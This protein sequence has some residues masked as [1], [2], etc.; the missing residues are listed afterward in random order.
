MSSLLKQKEKRLK[1]KKKCAN[2]LI[3]FRFH[4]Y[5]KRY[6]K[7]LSKNIS[8]KFQV[9]QVIR[10]GKPLHISLY[11]GFSTADE[12]EMIKKFVSICKRFDLVKFKLNGFDH[13]DKHVIYL[14]VKP[15]TELI[16]L[17]SELAKELNTTCKAQPWDMP[18]LDFIFH[19]TIAHG[20]I[21]EKFDEI[22]RYVSSLEI[23]N[24]DQ[25]LLR[26]TLL[27]KGKILREYDFIQREMLHRYEALSRRSMQ[28]T[29]SAL[30]EIKANGGKRLEI[31]LAETPSTSKKIFLISDLHLDHT[32]IIKYTKRPF[33]NVKEMNDILVSN[34]NNTV[35][36]QDTVYFLGDMAFGKGSHSAEYWLKKL[37][38]KIVFIEGNHED[39]KLKTFY[40]KDKNVFLKYKDEEFILTHDPALKP[41]GWKGWIIHG[42]HH[43]NHPTEFP[44]INSE[45]K[46]INVSVELIKYTPIEIDKILGKRGI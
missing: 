7:E 22:W 35:R 21:E 5:A 27:K 6:A 46:T 1:S 37:N 45:N 42:H 28:K 20:D 31:H 2:Y 29:I 36:N 23:P 32:N 10:K 12:N 13:I 39:I 41:K 38:G 4:G 25:C 40:S 34:W 14:N 18:E 8:R 44:L 33:K 43:N 19:T 24:I 30:K 9:K 16:G 17:R 26:A 11:G 15:S 3:E